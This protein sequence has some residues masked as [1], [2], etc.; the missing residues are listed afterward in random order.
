[1]IGTMFAVE[2]HGE[3]ATKGHVRGEFI[4]NGESYLAVDF[5]MVAIE[6][7]RKNPKSKGLTDE[8]IATVLIDRFRK[9]EKPMEA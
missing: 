4:V 9:P 5:A 1:L 6:T 7:E 2:A 8:E 3:K